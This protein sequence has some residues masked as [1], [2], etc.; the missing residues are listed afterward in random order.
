MKIGVNAPCPCNS[1][2]KYKK[3]CKPIEEQK[4]TTEGDKNKAIS[5]AIKYFQTKAKEQKVLESIGIYINF[6]QPVFFNGKYIWPIGNRFVFHEQEQTFHEFIVSYLKIRLENKWLRKQEKL[7]EN[8][9]HFLAKC[10]QK[11]HEK[12][13]EISSKAEADG[14]FSTIPSGWDQTLL[15]LAFD[16]ATL[17]HTMQLPQRLMN[18]LKNEDQFQGAKY[19]IEVAAI[20]ARLNYEINFLDNKEYQDI[21]HCEFIATHRKTG[22]S[23]AVEAKSR[24]RR[25][26]IHLPGSSKKDDLLKGDIQGLIDRAVSQ[27]PKDKPFIIFI[28]LNSPSTPN[29]ELPEKPWYK[30][31]SEI[32]E[33]YSKLSEE[34]EESW[35]AIFITNHSYHYQEDMDI[36]PSEGLTVINTKPPVPSPDKPF[37]S[38]LI[39]AVENYGKIPDYGADGVR[40]GK[41]LIVEEND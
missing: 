30:D 13:I 11:H 15:S 22:A 27:G 21:K 35:N 7:T 31:I 24:H 23:I 34:Q 32:F 5:E 18:R 26:V 39:N 2:K 36:I 40:L 1:G 6:V 16:V 17:E 25:G 9:R 14:F 10:F 33:N 38:I 28:D 8:K 12:Y 3:C 29:V 37:F 41:N 20:F 4:R 19:E